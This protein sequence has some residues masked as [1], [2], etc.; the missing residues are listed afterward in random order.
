MAAT[1]GQVLIPFGHESGDQ[2]ASREHLL[3]AGLEQ[4]C[5]VRGGKSRVV[6]D[7]R[8]VDARSGL[9]MKPL[10]RD[11][12]A[13]QAVDYIHCEFRIRSSAQNTVA[14]HPGSQGD[15]VPVPLVSHRMRIL[16]ENKVLVFRRHQGLEPHRMSL[17]YGLL[18]NLPGE[19]AS[20]SPLAEKKSTRKK[21]TPGSQGISRKVSRSIRASASG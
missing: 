4:C 1:A 11:A 7:C 8:L 3:Y 18:E 15:H 19:T 14:E 2:A 5:L 16:T 9:G 10:D 20:G 17:C 21:A 12:E 6:T 13:P